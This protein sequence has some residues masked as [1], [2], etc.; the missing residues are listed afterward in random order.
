MFVTV[1]YGF[2]IFALFQ[3]PKL[4]KYLGDRTISV[5]ILLQ[6]VFYYIYALSASLRFNLFILIHIVSVLHAL[7]NPTGHLLQTGKRLDAFH[8][9]NLQRILAINWSDLVTN[10]KSSVKVDSGA[11]S[12]SSNSADFAGLDMSILWKMGESTRTC[13]TESWRRAREHVDGRTFASGMSRKETKAGGPGHRPKQVETGGTR[14]TRQ[15]GE[16]AAE[17]NCGQTH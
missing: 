14:M 6:L 3:S 7:G 5:A 10:I 12:P 2:P 16:R 17:S 1:V 13:S 4:V 8:R 9:R 15:I 11:W